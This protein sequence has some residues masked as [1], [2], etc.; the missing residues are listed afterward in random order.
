VPA[1]RRRRSVDATRD[2]EQ[3]P[4]AEDEPMADATGRA[5][6][7]APGTFCWADLHAKDVQASKAFYMS[8]FA[9]RAAD[10]P[11]APGMTYTMFYKGDR[12]VCA[13]HSTKVPGHPTFWQAYFA[14]DSADALA[15][16]AESLGGRVV[17][18]PFDVL[19]VGRMAVVADP[20]G[21]TFAAWEARKHPGAGVM[22]EADTL[23]WCEADTSDL[24]R[25][26]DYYAKLFGWTTKVDG[27]GP[28]RY[29]HFKIGDAMFGGAM[30]IKKDWGPVPSH[31]AI[32][33]GV[34]DVD[35]TA[36]KATAAGGKT[37]MG[38]A[39]IPGTGRFAVI[40]D[41]EGATFQI[42]KSERH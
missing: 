31:W 18:A 4:S 29:V 8:T 16:K 15:K 5:R 11:A 2:G 40:A 28:D 33:F 19:D 14:V 23:V 35:A 26:I 25:T 17:Q 22:G 39:T 10:M 41:P 30:Q 1:T 7:F 6:R 9:W 37:V 13:L 12:D 3:I 34:D 38:P 27:E 32:C 24:D 36:S 42:F 20:T 21:A